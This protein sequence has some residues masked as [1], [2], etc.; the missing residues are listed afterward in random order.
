MVLASMGRSGGTSPVRVPGERR[1]AA[2]GFQGLCCPSMCNDRCMGYRLS[3]GP[4][5]CVSLPWLLGEFFA[6]LARAVHTWKYGAFFRRGLVSGSLVSGV[7]VLLAEYSL[8]TLREML[9]SF[10]AQCMARQ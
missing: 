9:P 4:S 2:A 1:G 3:Q 5:S 8:W 10:G 6:F 7:C